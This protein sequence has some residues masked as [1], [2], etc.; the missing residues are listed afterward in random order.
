M[1]RRSRYR[2][3]K[4]QLVWFTNFAGN[5]VSIR[6]APWLGV[7]VLAVSAPVAAER[8]AVANPAEF[9]SAVGSLR[10]GD[11]LVLKNG[12]W[13]DADLLFTGI[14]SAE[15]PIELLPETDG[16]VV[17]TGASSLR[18]AGSFLHARGLIFRNGYSPRG[19]VISFRGDAEHLASDSR[20]SEMVIDGYSHPDR[21]ETD[22]WVALYGRRNR[23]DHNHLQGKTNAGVTVAVRLD[24][25]G[26]RNNKHRIDHNYF[27]PR[28]I[29]GSN[30]GETLRIGTS[31][32]SMFNSNT[33]VE[34]N[35]FDHCSG[36]VE[37]ISS[38]SGGNVFRGNLFLASQGS[39]T[40]R[41]GD[42]SLVEDNVF[43]GLDEP[44]TG[45]V[46]VINQRQT[47][48]NNYME[49][50]LGSGFASALTVMNGVPNSPVNRYVQVS[51][52]LISHNSVLNSRQIA[53]G[54]GADVERSAAPRASRL[55]ENLFSPEAQAPSILRIDA[56]IAGLHA[57]NNVMLAGDEDLSNLETGKT[58]TGVTRR[59][60]LLVRAS[61]GL[62]YPADLRIKQGVSRQLKPLTRDEVGVRWYHPSGTD[63]KLPVITVE[64][65]DDTLFDALKNAADGSVLQLAAGDYQQTRALILDRRISL[66]GPPAG[67]GTSSSARATLHVSRSQL[68]LLQQGAQLTLTDINIVGDEAPDAVGNAVFRTE[69]APAA[70]AVR[71]R[72]ERVKV[73]N[74]RVNAGFDVVALA[75]NTMVEDVSIV[76]SDFSQISGRVLSATSENDDYGRYNVESLRI[77]KSRFT[78][79]GGPIA[80]IY[81]GGTDESTFGPRLVLRDS[82]LTRVGLGPKQREPAALALHGAQQ[83]EISGN[84]IR[85]SGGFA[86]THTVGEPMTRIVGNTFEAT[87]EPS[88]RELNYRGAAR[89]DIHGN[90]IKGSGK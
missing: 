69:A 35:V 17:L 50:L 56:D 70:S 82:T 81:R 6:S 33:V 25:K 26:S 7:L 68:F 64:P 87:P 61:S 73:S 24:S 57:R 83:T 21:F 14:G 46:R 63:K 77:E 90:Q 4:S 12:V 37:I 59:D 15:Q 13:T 53:L 3:G 22:Y 44:N 88:V 80:A 42:G 76:D 89:A 38:K 5:L 78:D 36:E 54:A 20:V 32:Y 2:E 27:G 55:E 40:L 45:G 23:F 58:V 60:S 30:G 1:N 85:D 16:G 10:P 51:G 74:L 41:H 49:G 19:E 39:L 86:L 72:L 65:G 28:P 79:I 34:R 84:E 9:S 8:L 18:L 29:L 47:V 43:L 66:I 71:L 31:A 52:A 11:Q 48:R 75:K 67:S 62:L